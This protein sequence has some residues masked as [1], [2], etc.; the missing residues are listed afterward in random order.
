MTKKENNN[1]SFIDKVKQTFDGND[2]KEQTQNEK[3]VIENQHE[4]APDEGREDVP[5]QDKV[6]RDPD[7]GEETFIKNDIKNWKRK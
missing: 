6:I 7:T 4:N 5:T 3:H 1:E 2:K